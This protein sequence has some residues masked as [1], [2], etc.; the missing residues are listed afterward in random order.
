MNTFYWIAGII[1]VVHILIR[2]VPIIYVLK[3]KGF[4]LHQL[5]SIPFLKQLT[6]FLIRGVINTF[7]SLLT[8]ILFDF[9]VI[10]TLFILLWNFYCA[11]GEK[12][13]IPSNDNSISHILNSKAFESAFGDFNLLIICFPAVFFSLALV[14]HYA[15]K[16]NDKAKEQGKKP[17]YKGLITLGGLTLLFDGLAIYIGLKIAHDERSLS[18]DYNG[19]WGDFIRHYLPQGVLFLFCGFVSVIFFGILLYCIR[20]H[21]NRFSSSDDELRSIIDSNLEGLNE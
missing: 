12:I 10:S 17:K 15:I 3:N 9:A 20:E 2:I 14:V 16:N 18:R 7:I 1:V 8:S 19:T 6:I 4:P 21:F 13:F 5:I 11:I